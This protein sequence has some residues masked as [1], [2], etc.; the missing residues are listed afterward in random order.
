MITVA[1][2]SI[3]TMKGETCHQIT[4]SDGTQVRAVQGG[5]II[6]TEWKNGGEWI[7]RAK[8]YVVVRNRKRQG[9][10]LV[11]SVKRFLSA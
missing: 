7:A 11:E 6:R 3:Y 8:P 9:E 4:Y 5:G 2:A 10:R 1:D